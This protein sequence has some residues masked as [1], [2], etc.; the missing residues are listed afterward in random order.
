MASKKKSESEDSTRPAPA[1]GTRPAP[2]RGRGRSEESTAPSASHSAA[3]GRASATEAGSYVA[4]AVPTAVVVE[5]EIG[6]RTLSI[7][8]GRMARQADGAVV[9]RYGD[10]IVLATAQSQKAPEGIDFFPLTVDYREKT[11]AAGLI[12]GGFFKREG[13][14]TTK[15][16][17]GCRIIDRSVRPMFPDGYRA[18][19]QVLSQVL[20]TDRENDPDVA[21]AIASFA[22]LALSSIPHG[23]T[24][25]MCRIGLRDEK[26]LVN[27]T[28]S[29][30]QSPENRLNLT[31]AGHEDAIVMV[32]SGA[33]EVSEEVMLEALQLGHKIAG[34]IAAMIEELRQKAGR[35]KKAFEPPKRDAALLKAIEEQFGDQL[36]QA[37]LTPGTKQMRSA[38]TKAAKEAATAAFPPPAGLEESQQKV[39]KS[40][41][42]EI[43]GDII[44]D[45]ERQSILRGK[46]ADGR[47]HA[48]IRPITIE[49]GVLPRVHGS[50]LFTRGETQS[51]GI[52]T[53]GGTD[54]QQIIDGLMPE[55]KKRF[56]LHYN[57]P[58]FSV[59][60][61][62]R[63]GSPGRREIGHGALAERGVEP[64]LPPREQ[65]PYTIRVTSEILESNGSSSM[66]T[67]CAATLSLMDA[68]VPIKQPV[69]GIAMGLVME[70]KEYAILSDILGSEDGC[71]DMDFKVVGTQYGITA[72]Q[73]DIKCDG[74]TREILAQALEQAR[75][76]RIH[77]L[78]K[79]LEVL[80][81]PRPELSPNAPRLESLQIPPDK[82]GL[83]IGPAGKNIR[84]LQEQ[85]ECR[86]SIEDGGLCTVT[87]LVAE[88]VMACVEHLK[89][90]TAEVE[91]G[92][93]YEGRVTAIKEFGAF[94]EI[95][96]GQ[97]G[98]CHVSEL[99]DS[100]I[101]SVTDVVRIGD[102]VKVKVIGIDDFGKV[103]LSRK[104]LLVGERG[105]KPADA[106]GAPA[107]EGQRPMHEER[108]GFRGERG[109]RPERP[110]D[111]GE[112]G[113]FRGE[114]GPRPE[115]P[116][117]RGERGGFRGERGPRP[118]RSEDRG[119]RGEFRGGR[120]PRPERPE[121]RGERGGFRGDR[122]ERGE[123]GEFEERGPRPEREERGEFR[124]ERGERGPR[125]EREDRGGFRGERG[126]RAERGERGDFRGEGER[127]GYRGDRE[128]R[129][130][131]PDRGY[132]GDRDERSEHDRSER[133]GDTPDAARPSDRQS[134]SQSRSQSERRPARE[135]G[136]GPFGERPD[137]GARQH[138]RDWGEREDREPREP[139]EPREARDPR[140]S[141]GS[142]RES[143]PPMA[144]FDTTEEDLLPVPP[145]A[146]GGNEVG[147]LEDADSLFGGDAPG[148]APGG[149][150]GGAGGDPERRRRRGGRRRR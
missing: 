106:A 14:P 150:S 37:P 133:P 136:E 33:K 65:F 135:R 34:E 59:G 98:L 86:I 123:R 11:S 56:L 94:I 21:A 75:V 116:E 92:Q 36:R 110:E 23:R 68:G 118:E 71:G 97:E 95:L 111:R 84:Q 108:G 19:V 83:V 49:V 42:A 104:A 107:P 103:K 76:G 26:L 50:V 13:R 41:L 109:P 138:R 78:K 18:E 148:D 48:T 9:V 73:M 137:R 96:P 1:R 6:G 115:R 64:V 140:Q 51:L 88:K 8:T 28:W 139:R 82:I 67:V 7:E 125:P 126:P 57:F 72:L 127:G 39:W 124:G 105:G 100:F 63:T 74:L 81:A 147:D 66:A 2:R 146:T 89:A 43:I 24:L 29:V 52:V 22:A 30:L 93:I 31:V 112:R 91:V 45:G 114:R 32:E 12:P 4:P 53:L 99:A 79:M 142:G 3:G 69:A 144:E 120:G 20:A 15:E 134:E 38:A 101:R 40:A 47:D 87:G 119:E 122:A 141:R 130:D 10:T 54:D 25:G 132:R 17:L 90:M 60:E 16:I 58:P 5:R 102:K 62:K 113:G 117:D 46:R 70:G 55:P 44:K 27:P 131:R 80:R 121:D 145:E 143:T 35:P 77:V 85:F 129:R 149:A 61:V 128:G